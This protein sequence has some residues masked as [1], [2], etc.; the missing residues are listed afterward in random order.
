MGGTMSSRGARTCAAMLGLLAV[1]VAHTAAAAV[2][3]PDFDGVVWTP[4]GCDA[5]DLI[6][7]ASPAAVDFAGD[8]TFP[9][10]YFAHD[11]SYLYFRYRVDGD[12]Y[13]S[14]TFA[15]YAWTALMQVPS[16]DPFQYQY[17]LSLNGKS[18]AREIWQNTVAEDI[19]FCPLFRDVSEVRLFSQRYDRANGSTGNTTP[20]AR[21]LP[22]GDGSR[23]GDDT[24]YFLDFAFP[25]PV[26][27]A[28][29]LIATAA[30]LDQSVYFAATSADPNNYNKSHLNCPF[31]PGTD[32]SVSVMATP[33]TV[34]VNLTT[35][36]AFTSTVHNDG[37]GI[38]KGV[39]IDNS[40]FPSFVHNVTVTVTSDDPSVT[41]T[42][43]SSNPLQVRLPYLPSGATLTIQVSADATPG[44]G[45]SDFTDT[46][47]VSA[48][49]AMPTAGSAVLH[50][51]LG[52][53]E[54]C[55]GVDNNCDG[56]IDEGGSALCDDG[57]ACNGAE[58]CGGAAGCQPGTPPSCDDWNACTVDGCD[59]Q[60][61]C[62]HDPIPSCEP[63]ATAADCDDQ[64]ACTT[65]IC[66]SGVCAHDVIPGCVPCATAADCGDG[67][68][69]TTDSCDAGACAHATIP[70]C[71]P[72]ATAADCDDRNACTT[73]A[74]DAG[75][76]AH[77]A[78]P[79]CVLCTTAADCDDR[80][81]CTTEVCNAD[82]VC[83]HQLQEGCVPCGTAADC[84]D[85]NPCTTDAC[86]PDGSCQLSAIPGP[87][88][89][90]TAADC[91]D[92]TAA[93]TNTCNAGAGADA[94]IPD[95]VA[96]CATAA[97]C[98]GQ[99][100]TTA[101]CGGGDGGRELTALRGRLWR[102]QRLHDR[103]VQRRRLRACHHLR[104]R[105]LH[106]RCGLQR[107]QRLHH[108]HLR[109]GRM[110]PR[111]HRRLCAVHDGGR[112]WRRQR[113]HDRHMQRR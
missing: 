29:G 74:C 13:G 22:A 86:G 41:P 109:R 32:L 79:G 64:N 73:D 15:Q 88:P 89:P 33:D 3:N 5:P 69:C 48:V 94:K 110:R 107:R 17:Q 54:V 7:H 11:D 98:D 53:A 46:T 90:D 31:L 28:N 103:H 47:S 85:Q 105:P 10:A 9:A 60:R 8:A 80:D 101:T 77:A 70:G 30:D 81:G 96:R 19:N 95:C 71:V 97:C 42:V 50:I 76:C 21:S 99:D 100:P 106:R 35:P 1:L 102:R 24:D 68:A 37:P 59:P 16:G 63:C 111:Q 18:D 27:I 20:L 40:T 93:T 91:T 92:G 6:S 104:V 87:Q 72:C 82:G 55:D 51:Q 67:N 78:I 56:R 75:A 23:F 43:V 36:V 108:R 61:G 49:D 34:P 58:I 112:L 44:C 57:N 14:G 45:D 52:N 113:L 4:L 62:T 66:G 83:E 84:G 26:M 25:V 12:P 39:V 38:A 2:A 65:D